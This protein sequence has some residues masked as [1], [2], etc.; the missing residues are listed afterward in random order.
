LPRN[1]ERIAFFISGIVQGVGF[2]PFV[3]KLAQQYTL[4]GFVRNGSEGVYVEVEGKVDDI[5]LFEEMLLHNTPPLARIDKYEKKSLHVRGEKGFVIQESTDGDIETLVLPDVSMCATCKEEML[6]VDDRR[7][8]YALI[9]CTD[10]GP[11]Y[12]L[13]QNLPY[14]RKNTTMKEFVMCEKCREEYSNPL[15]RRYHAQPISCPECGPQIYLC[16]ED[17][18]QEDDAIFQK[19]ATLLD[20]GKT[21]ALKGLGG[22]HLV[23]DATNEEAVQTLRKNKNRPTK[24]LAVMYASLE[25]LQKDVCLTNEE[26]ELLCSQERPIV[27]VEKS[28]TLSLAPSIAPNIS[29]VGVFLAYTPLHE[30]LLH[31]YNKPIVATSANLSGEPIITEEKLLFQKLSHVVSCALSHNRVIQNGCDDSVV[32]AVAKEP[33]FLRLAR[34]YAPLS[35]YRKDTSTCKV[36]A[37][38]A[39]Q[40]SSITLGF[41]EH[42]ICSPYIGDLDSLESLEYFTQ[43]VETFCRLYQFKPEIIVSDMHPNYETTRWAKEYVAKYSGVKHISVQHHYAH[44]LSVMAEYNLTQEYIAFC[45]DGTGY[46]DDGVLWGGEVLRCSLK[47]YE[48]IGHLQ[49][50]KLLGGEKAIKEPKRVGLSLLFEVMCFEEVCALKHPLVQS[51]SK[52]E[53]KTLYT[54]YSKGLNA[55]LAT[56][57]GRLFDGVYSLCGFVD[58]V[59]YEGESGLFL[60]SLAL[61][62]KHDRCYTYT[63]EN[64]VI[65]YEMMIKEMLYEEDGAFIARKFINTL[66]DIVCRVSLEHNQE[67]L[68]C[69]GVFQNSVLVATIIELFEKHHITYYIQHKTPLNDGSISLGQ[70]YY[71]LKKEDI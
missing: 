34:G 64:G 11:R 28:K 6:S 55:P 24:P 43:T 33:L 7:Y 12:T 67:I 4:D 48:R 63:I 27:I 21:I 26:K 47:G 37:L 35:F 38:G 1:F 45:F 14:D 50:L 20:E 59:S 44:A 5:A 15:S 17:G 40:K 18:T 62:C 60:E 52:Q 71:A 68:L 2:R 32:M 54:M 13:L 31:Q 41:Y 57:I 30:L 23:C 61:T 70:A 42:L 66:A 16:F 8:G 46:G 10:C 3:Y 53:L 25:A 36:L 51:F 69:G 65:S 49:T 9:N 29:K 19:V 58:G 56:S 39:N 22:F